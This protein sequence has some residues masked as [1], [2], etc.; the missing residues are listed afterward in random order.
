MVGQRAF[1]AEVW[2]ER[3]LSIALMALRTKWPS[4]APDA[5]CA[6]QNDPLVEDVEVAEDVEDIHGCCELLAVWV[7]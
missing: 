4:E 7:A 5:S 2:P 6:L 3:A 1:G